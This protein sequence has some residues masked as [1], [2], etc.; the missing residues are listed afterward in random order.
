MDTC[1][2]ILCVYM[3]ILERMLGKVKTS[4]HEDVHL[5]MFV[6]VFG[7]ESDREIYEEK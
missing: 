7:K 5:V 6:K 4:R 3:Y 2:K 1:K